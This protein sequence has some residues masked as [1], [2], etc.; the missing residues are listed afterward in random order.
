MR[1]S[2]TFDNGPEPGATEGVLDAL[3]HYAILATF[4]VVG[5]KLQSVEAQRLIDRARAE[6]HRIGNH[7]Y[8]HSIP[9]GQLDDAEAVEEIA[10]TQRL[11]GERAP[12]RLFRPYGVEGRIGPH[13]LND[14]AAAYLVAGGFTCVLW[15]AVPGDWKDPH[16]WVETAMG[17]CAEQ[18]FSLIVLHDVPTGA[19]AHLPRFIEQ[20]QAARAEFT[21]DYPAPCVPI[22]SGVPAPDLERYVTAGDGRRPMAQDALGT[23]V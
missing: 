11:L 6:G 19:M 22:R 5:R 13:L 15:N 10:A 17:M 23:I 2:L 8:S 7:T 9:L 18:D 21:Q 1:V 20:L 4:F 14:A 3:A 16:G 12:E